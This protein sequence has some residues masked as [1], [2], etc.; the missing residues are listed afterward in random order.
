[1]FTMLYKYP[2]CSGQSRHAWAPAQPPST[3]LRSRECS[4]SPSRRRRPPMLQSLPAR[5][6]DLRTTPCA[7]NGHPGGGPRDEIPPA[8]KPPPKCSRWWT[9]DSGDPVRHGGGGGCGHPEGVLI[10]TGRGRKPSRTADVS[11]GL[12]QVLG[13][14]AGRGTGHRCRKSPP[15]W[16]SPTPASARP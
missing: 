6:S 2:F 1:M 16:R 9:D 14:A 13:S 7:F 8:T 4:A 11:F 10:I 3:T 15:W 12:E 5:T